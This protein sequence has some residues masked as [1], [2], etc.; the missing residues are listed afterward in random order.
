MSNFIFSSAAAGLQA[1]TLDLST[2]N[3]YAHIVTSV[4]VLNN[5]TVADLVLPTTTGYTSAALTGLS[6]NA[7]RWTFANFTFPKY[8]FAAIPTGVVICKLS[9]ATPAATDI[10]ICYSDFNNS[11]GQV[12]TLVVGNYLVNLTFGVNGAIN[13]LYRYRYSSGAF[14]T[15]EAIP[16]GSLF[17]IGSKNNT[18]AFSNP[19]MAAQTNVNSDQ[20]GAN[21]QD[22]RLTDRSISQ[23]A[24]YGKVALDFGSRAIRVG[25]FRFNM[26]AVSSGAG[27][28]LFGAN[29]LD[30]FNSLNV[31]DS[32]KWTLIGSTA[33]PG[34]PGCFSIPVTNQTYWQYIKFQTNTLSADL[35]LTELEFYNSQVLSPTINFT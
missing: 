16:K 12:L 35:P 11:I 29:N 31:N 33:N 17:M 20:N 7:N 15:G 34:S 32:T 27:L 13:F 8:L 28:S 1:G 25:D 4:P 9:G 23:S 22:L 6:Y 26:G 10:I 18:V 19:F 3:Y 24:Y 21:A 30:A 5:T 2:G 14:V